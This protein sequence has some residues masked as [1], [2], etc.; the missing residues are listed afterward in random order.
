LILKPDDVM[1]LFVE[2]DALV[3]QDKELTVN[4][5]GPLVEPGAFFIH[6]DHTGG[7]L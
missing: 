4:D 1:P 7:N 3:K 5:G 2:T 6:I